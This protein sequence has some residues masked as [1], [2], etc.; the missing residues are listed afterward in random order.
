[1]PD[2]PLRNAILFCPFQSGDS[3]VS[4]LPTA[5]QTEMRT[6]RDWSRTS[7]DETSRDV[8]DN[9]ADDHSAQLFNR[10]SCRDGESLN[11]HPA[12][13]YNSQ[14]KATDGSTHTYH[15]PLL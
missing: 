12:S 4:P 6:M 10:A 11:A 8:A 15:P 5:A 3:P 1:M 13:D 2:T 9:E 7:R 14:W